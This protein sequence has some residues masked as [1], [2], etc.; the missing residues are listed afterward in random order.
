MHACFFS[1][2]IN[3]LCEIVWNCCIHNKF[4]SLYGNFANYGIS[5]VLGPFHWNSSRLQDSSPAWAKHVRQTVEFGS[6][7]RC[8]R[9]SQK[10]RDRWWPLSMIELVTVFDAILSSRQT[11]EKLQCFYE[12]LMSNNFRNYKTAVQ[13]KNMNFKL[14]LHPQGFYWK[15]LRA[16]HALENLKPRF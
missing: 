6:E 1:M 3:Y 12:N 11:C 4:M 15:K 8:I 7:L 5:L 2:H 16:F 13:K 10:Q 9:R 14:K